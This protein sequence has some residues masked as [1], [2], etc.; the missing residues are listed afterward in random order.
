MVRNKDYL[1]IC[2]LCGSKKIIKTT[3]INKN[4]LIKL[5]EKRFEYNIGYLFENVNHISFLKCESCNLKYFYPD[6]SGDNNFYKMLQKN[7]FYYYDDKWEY[8]II[9][10]YFKKSLSILEIGAGKGALSKI[11]DY[12][13]YT[14]LELNESAIKTAKNNNVNLSHTSIQDY[15]EK[16]EGAFDIVC[17]F[18]VLE[19]VILEDL[20][21]FIKASIKALKKR[22]K[23]IIAIPSDKSYLNTRPNVT[24]NFPPHHI[25]RWPTEVFYK[26]E[27][28]FNIKLL[29][30]YYEPLNQ[31]QYNLFLKHKILEKLNFNLPMIKNKKYP[32]ERIISKL[33]KLL[34]NCIKE[35]II[36]YYNPVGH[37]IV[38]I[39]EKL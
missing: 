21:S 13:T 36:N 24:L 25:T 30:I 38:L 7:H 28:I 26:F 8:R 11:M 9:N 34:P 16:N 2:P 10:N 18:Q 20:Y 39:F 31:A 6:I 4:S 1:N 22:G 15:A 19:H 29:N 27:E 37:S 12:K 17:S 23:M 33:T 35:K 3:E 5:Y 14:G 32:L